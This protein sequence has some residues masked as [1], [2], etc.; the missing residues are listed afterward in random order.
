VVID[1]PPLTTVID[2]LPLARL[3]D[4]VLV[5]AR[6]SVS[7]LSKISELED[8]LY[9]QDQYPTGVVLIGDSPR[10]RNAYDYAPEES[11]QT[12]FRRPRSAR[13]PRERPPASEPVPTG[14]D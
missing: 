9:E 3:A 2:A 14:S 8:L 6:L 7:K 13:G 10:R 5:V 12:S 1:A 11:G 4:D